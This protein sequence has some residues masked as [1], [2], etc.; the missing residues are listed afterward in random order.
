MAQAASLPG[1]P[2][3][4]RR[5]KWRGVVSVVAF[6]VLWQ[7]AVV[8]E[9]AGFA[10]LPTPLQTLRT[11][12]ADYVADPDYWASWVISFERVFYG[13]IIAQVV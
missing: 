10:E 7:L 3:R 13:F 1:K 11:F 5:V 6:F 4:W 9:L 12:F 8:L 2:S